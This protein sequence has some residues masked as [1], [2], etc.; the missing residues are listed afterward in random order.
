[1]RGETLLCDERAHLVELLDKRRR[2]IR[3]S[4][5]PAQL[6]AKYGVPESTVNKHVFRQNNA[7]LYA[8]DRYSEAYRRAIN[9]QRH[10]REQKAALSLN[11][12]ADLFGVH[13]E[14]IRAVERETRP[15]VLNA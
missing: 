3:A 13:R 11:S 1:M 10:Y 8:S 7:R 2:V 9:R 12:L 6:A 5:T 4:R 14:L 15:G